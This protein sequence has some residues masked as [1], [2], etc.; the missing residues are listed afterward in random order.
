MTRCSK[1]TKDKGV[2]KDFEKMVSFIKELKKKSRELRRTDRGR[3]A[4]GC[5][6]RESMRK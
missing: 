3:L 6:L 5:I 4:G 1:R 2:K